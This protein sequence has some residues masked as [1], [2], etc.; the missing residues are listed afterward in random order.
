MSRVIVG[1]DGSRNS[2]DALRWA[3][4]RA[5]RTGDEVVAV[6]AWS[7]FD[8]GQLTPGESM[9]P[10]FSD[11]DA[12]RVLARVVDPTGLDGTVRRHTI[13]GK[14]PEGITGYASP[15]DLIVVGARG[16]GGFK[17]LLLGSVSQRVLELAPCP[18]AVIREGGHEARGGE[19]VVGVDGSDVSVRALHWAAA[20]AAALGAP[21]RIV[22][23][24]QWPLFAE[25]AAPEVYEA[26]EDSA[27]GVLAQAA[28]DPSLDGLDVEVEAVN[29]G[30]AQALLAHDAD[31][32][33]FVVA[34][35][36]RGSLERLV[37]GSTSRQLTQH[38]TA[39]VVVVRSRD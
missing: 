13:N 31:A 7:F 6:F 30:A 25:L 26:L 16:L 38:A 4:A 1:I 21:I 32:A 12:R 27:A 28:A 2:Q 8:Q 37:L 22:H 35:R 5:E 34:A 29:G 36:G 39:P 23:A 10:E 17:G 9:K 24:W 11:E 33:M 3:A 14:A 18:V 20:E 15:D 19:I